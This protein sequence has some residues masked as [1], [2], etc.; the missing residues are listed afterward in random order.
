MLRHGGEENSSTLL[1]RILATQIFV[2]GAPVGIDDPLL[3]SIFVPNSLDT[4]GMCFRM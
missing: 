3:T 4:I 2:S 1:I